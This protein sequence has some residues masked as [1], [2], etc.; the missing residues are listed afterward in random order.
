M[1]IASILNESASSSQ[2]KQFVYLSA[3]KNPMMREYGEYKVKAEDYLIN[4]CSNLNAVLLRPGV[5]TS[6]QRKFMYPLLP[7]MRAQNM[8]L[9]KVLGEQIDTSVELQQVVKACEKG[10]KG[11]IESGVVTNDQ[12][13]GLD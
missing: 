13:V 12:L 7:F 11:E 8:L 10:V 9:G 6:S 4:E 5:V 3:C 2:K 1:N